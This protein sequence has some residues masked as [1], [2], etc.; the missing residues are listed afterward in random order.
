M[1]RVFVRHMRARYD[2]CDSTVI[3]YN[4]F[5]STGV[6]RRPGFRLPVLLERRFTPIDGIKSRRAADILIGPFL[7]PRR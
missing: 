1:R 6:L 2:F 3:G 5:I 4:L 7:T